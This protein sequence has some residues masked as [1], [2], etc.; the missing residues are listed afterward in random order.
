P[1]PD[2]AMT[3]RLAVL[4]AV[5]ML[6]VALRALGGEN[7]TT[8]QQVFDG[9]RESFVAEKAKGVHAR[10]QF[11]FT[12]PDGGDWW[13]EVNDGKY[14]MARGKI[15][16]PDVTMLASDKDW[17]ALSNGT[18]NGTWAFVT[19]RLKIRGDRGVAKKLGE[20]FP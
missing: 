16:N 15:E 8:P 6:S 14:K 13:I 11:T 20:V 9:M 17:V 7:S 5:L 12:G 2:R 3:M 18:L 10:Y 19:G 1:P 4:S